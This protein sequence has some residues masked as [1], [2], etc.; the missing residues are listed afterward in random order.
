MVHH[1]GFGYS[2]SSILCLVYPWLCPVTCYMRRLGRCATPQ[3]RRARRHPVALPA[4]RHHGLT[5]KKQSGPELITYPT[6][7]STSDADTLKRD[8]WRDSCF[9]LNVFAWLR[10]RALRFARR[11]LS[12]IPL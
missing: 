5:K 12:E 11:A 9:L 1:S 7:P 6:C 3:Q 2:V 4:A 8:W 10:R